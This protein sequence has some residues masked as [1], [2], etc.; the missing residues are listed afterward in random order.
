M[1]IDILKLALTLHLNKLQSFL[2]WN[3]DYLQLLSLFHVS[4]DGQLVIIKS[5]CNDHVHSIHTAYAHELDRST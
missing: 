5:D 3:L 2:S 1:L 4:Q